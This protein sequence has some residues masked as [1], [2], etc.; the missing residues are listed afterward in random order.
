[1]N[2]EP[3]CQSQGFSKPTNVLLAIAARA[4]SIRKLLR[5]MGK[6]GDPKAWVLLRD[7]VRSAVTIE[8]VA[9]RAVNLAAGDATAAVEVLELLLDQ[10]ETEVARV[11]TV[12]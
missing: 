2:A 8:A 4:R 1:M 11:T 7:V 9:S 5:S 6:Q 3:K 10:L 12:R